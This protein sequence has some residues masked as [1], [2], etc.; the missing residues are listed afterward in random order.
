[1]LIVMEERADNRD[2]AVD[3]SICEGHHKMTP[4]E[5]ET[6]G[7]LEELQGVAD[8]TVGAIERIRESIACSLRPAPKRKARR[9]G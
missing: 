4:K 3:V 5:M 1:M 9:I 2:P 6:Y 7:K 8:E